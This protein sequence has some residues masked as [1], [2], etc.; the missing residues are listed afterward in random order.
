MGGR[1]YG[2][3]VVNEEGGYREWLGFVVFLVGGVWIG[4]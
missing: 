1:L 2:G 4:F 3:V